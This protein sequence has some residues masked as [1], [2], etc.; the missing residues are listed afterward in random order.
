MKPSAAAKRVT[1]GWL[2]TLPPFLGAEEHGLLG[3]L[4]QEAGDPALR[5]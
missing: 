5:R 2:G 4:D 1:D 3:K